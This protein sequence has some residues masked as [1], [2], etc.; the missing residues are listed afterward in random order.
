MQNARGT[1]DSY[2]ILVAKLYSWKNIEAN[3]IKMNIMETCCE[4]NSVKM[5]QDKFQW[6]KSV[7]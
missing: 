7:D 3:S 6:I 4:V 5:V 2:K 1:K